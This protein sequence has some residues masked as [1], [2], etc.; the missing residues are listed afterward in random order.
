MI[1]KMYGALFKLIMI[2]VLAMTLGL[3]AT[4]MA[5]EKKRHW[6]VKQGKGRPLCEALVNIANANPSVDNWRPNIPWQQVLAI[7]GVSEPK[8]KELDPLKYE[9]F[10]LKVRKYFTAEY[11]SGDHAMIFS[12]WFLAPKEQRG[13]DRKKKLTD[14]EALK[15]YRAFAKVGGKLKAL[16]ANLNNEAKPII[17]DFVQYEKKDLPDWSG[18]TLEAEPGL[19]GIHKAGFDPLQLGAGYRIFMYDEKVYSFFGHNRGT[20]EYRVSLL[21]G[22]MERDEQSPYALDSFYCELDSDQGMKDKQ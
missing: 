8:W 19:A 21:T 11:P 20:G 10:F 15:I 2:L 3:A 5:D 18:Y 7:K 17:R 22:D 9:D 16:R 14:E 1:T 6:Y 4:A 13:F 12:G